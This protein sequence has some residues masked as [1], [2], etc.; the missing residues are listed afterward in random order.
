M[1]IIITG[2]RRWYIPDVAESVV[3]RFLAR[4]GPGIVVAP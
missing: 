1:R 3:A 4:Y 2:C